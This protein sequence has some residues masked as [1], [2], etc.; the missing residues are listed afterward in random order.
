MVIH[1]HL[2]FK[3]L[4]TL[5]HFV[6]LLRNALYLNEFEFDYE[7]ENNWA[8]TYDD[9][10]ISINISKPFEEG[11]LQEWDSSVP[12]GCNFGISLMS[13]DNNFYYDPQKY[14]DYYVVN[15]LIPKYANA[16]EEIIKSKVYYYRGKHLIAS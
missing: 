15:K 9:D 5:D 4:L 6:E 2:A 11:K 14:N 10:H 12:Q 3:S 1:E 13:I 8:W 16:V 7:N